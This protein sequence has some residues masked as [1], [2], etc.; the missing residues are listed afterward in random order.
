MTAH[1]PELIIPEADRMRDKEYIETLSEDRDAS[2]EIYTQTKC[3]YSE[4][5]IQLL[6]NNKQNNIKI[7]DIIEKGLISTCFKR[8]WASTPIIAKNGVVIGGL[9]ELEWYFARTMIDPNKIEY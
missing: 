9:P 8:G 6:Q 7:I 4:K 1:R 2:W 5:A 3:R